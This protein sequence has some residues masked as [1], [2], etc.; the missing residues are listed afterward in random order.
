[1]FHVLLD[2]YHYRTKSKLL[3]STYRALRICHVV[4]MGKSFN[5]NSV[6]SSIKWDCY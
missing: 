5:V 4:A 3:Y 2:V 1:M 6:S